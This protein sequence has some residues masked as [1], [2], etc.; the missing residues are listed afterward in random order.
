MLM[1]NVLNQILVFASEACEKILN[2]PYIIQNKIIDDPDEPG[3]KLLII[4]VGIDEEDIKTVLEV[5]KHISNYVRE[6][7]SKELGEEYQK[8]VLIVVYG[9][10]P[11]MLCRW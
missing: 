1:E 10:K 7:I 9:H 3:E 4:C 5:W 6:K 8:I 2:V 11:P